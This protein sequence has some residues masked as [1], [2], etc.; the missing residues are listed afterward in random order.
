M[1]HRRLAAWGIVL[2]VLCAPGLAR[3][4][5]TPSRSAL[6]IVPANAAFFAS[7]SRQE[8]QLH[9]LWESNAF[10]ELLEIPRVRETLGPLILGEFDLD[11]PNH[12][13]MKQWL[14][15]PF[16]QAGIDALSHEVFVYGDASFTQVVNDAN[17][18]MWKAT[19]DRL[20][21]LAS[22]SSEPQ[23]GL[24]ASTSAVRDLEGL[25][26][27]NLVFG[28][29][30]KDAMRARVQ[31]MLLDGLIQIAFARKD[32]PPL[33]RKQYGREM[34]QGQMFLTFTT[35]GE[36]LLDQIEFAPSEAI[37]SERLDRFVRAFRQRKIVLAVG[38]LHDYI[39]LSVGS[40]TEHLHHLG[41]KESL[42]GHPHMARITQLESRSCASI[43]Y[44]S[45]D[46]RTA[47]SAISG[48]Q[49]RFRELFEESLSNDGQGGDETQ[50]KAET[51]LR[52]ARDA[53]K[54][55]QEEEPRSALFGY[56]CL[57][58]TGYEGFSYRDARSV[59]P[60]TRPMSVLLHTGADPIGVFASRQWL[61]ARE[62][63]DWLSKQVAA[64]LGQFDEWFPVNN[65][66]S[67]VT[68][69][70][71]RKL[72]GQLDTIMRQQVVPMLAGGQAASVI[73]ASE[74]STQWHPEMP[75]AET[76][77]PLP[78]VSLV[79]ES[80]DPA[81]LLAGLDSAFQV[82]KSGIRL[83]SDAVQEIPPVEPEMED[84]AVGRLYFLPMWPELT[85]IDPDLFAPTVGYSDHWL[86]ATVRPKTAMTLLEPKGWVPEGVDSNELAELTALKHIRPE[87]LIQIALDWLG[88]AEQTVME[89]PSEDDASL[90]AVYRS[91]LQ[92]AACWKS[93]T[94]TVRQDG[95]EL[96]T[97]SIWCFEDR[98]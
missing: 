2:A 92:L 84:T 44:V 81:V 30:P 36:T 96:V 1:S 48:Y 98:P 94:C 29:K 88:Y 47:I 87:K 60:P 42:A 14:S 95:D 27:P 24:A 5:D 72:V 16:V 54:Q 64:R 38:F 23:A 19:L 35:T 52:E 73:S 53:R 82:V 21:A 15:Q 78:A 83:V 9:F 75:V 40:T 91:V 33:L 66:E 43:R 46:F 37:L 25:H 90:L 59:A 89:A 55:Q 10:A 17:E 61:D 50:T 58:D 76:P 56:T 34:I 77:L 31:L 63:Y 97:H 86:V 22:G 32:V 28:F 68:K 12:V 71:F 26:L 57:T 74:R 6:D 3:A 51:V 65:E 11:N 39:I 41:L 45:S 67:R 13:T 69:Q 85:R 93:Y 80:T 4:S 18:L 7:W 70:Q 62:D 20:E 8:E 49:P 79:V